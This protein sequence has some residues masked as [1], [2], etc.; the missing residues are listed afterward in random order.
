M[1]LSVE[2]RMSLCEVFGISGV[3]EFDMD[4]EI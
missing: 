3:H 2:T 4:A 1:R